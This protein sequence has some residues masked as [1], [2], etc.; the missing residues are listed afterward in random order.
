MS[1]AE[2]TSRRMTAPTTV[3]LD[4]ATIEAIA[5][6]TAELLRN[7]PATGE[8]VD[9][10]EI[11]R[12]FNVS[13]EYVYEHAAELGAVRLGHGPKARLRFDPEHAAEALAGPTA[14]DAER[15]HPRRTRRR[16]PTSVEL[17]PVGSKR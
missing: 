13:R 1:S 9:A 2:V 14:A 17:L 5:E 16:R 12:R 4:A 15:A 7:Q 10:A 8:L 6:R 11:A 3:T